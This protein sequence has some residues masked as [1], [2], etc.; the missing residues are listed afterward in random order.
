MARARC[1]ESTMAAMLAAGAPMGAAAQSADDVRT[2]NQQV[3]QL[4]GQ[5]KYK[6]AASVAERALAAAERVLGKEHPSTLTSVNNLA[7]LY[8][9]RGRHAEAGRSISPC[10]IRSLLALIVPCPVAWLL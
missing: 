9:S 8:D 4:F 1:Y 5:G 2:L 7:V 10:S 6:E 3:V